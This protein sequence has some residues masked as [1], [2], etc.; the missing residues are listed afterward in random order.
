MKFLCYF[1]MALYLSG[2]GSDDKVGMLKSGTKEY[3]IICIDGVEYLKTSSGYR[4]YFG[5]HF[6][7]DGSL[8]LCGD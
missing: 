5:V 3:D 7:Q 1:I 6:R 8:Y 4:G 2:C